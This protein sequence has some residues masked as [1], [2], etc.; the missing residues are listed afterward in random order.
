M[1]VGFGFDAHRFGGLPPVLLGGVAVDAKVGVVATSDG[2]VVSHALADAILG[3]ASLG[4]IG[5]HFPSTDSRWSGANSLDL[6]SAVVRMAVEA[7]LSVHHADVTVIAQD[8]VVAP[9]REEIRKRLAAVLGTGLGAVSV[10]AT[11]TDGLGFIGQGQGLAATAVVTL[12]DGEAPRSGQ[13]S[14]NAGP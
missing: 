7:G 3:A 4:D 5:Q 8:V 1:R 13:L 11:T 2:D 6:L 14:S 10:K 12:S 9:Y